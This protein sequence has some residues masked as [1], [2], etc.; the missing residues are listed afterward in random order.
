MP[1]SPPNP[2]INC[3]QTG[4]LRL[5]GE[6][7]W[8][9]NATF[10]VDLDCAGEKVEAVYKPIKG[11]Q[12]LWDFPAESL[13]CREVAAYLLSEALGWGLVPPTVYRQQGPLG[14]GSLQWRVPHDPALHYFEFNQE[15]R[16]ALRP[17]ALFDLIANNADRKGGHILVAE[18]GGF[19]LIDQGLCF[20]AEAK[21]RTVIWDFRGEA[22]PADLL[23]DLRR[24]AAN[25]DGLR[26][27][28]A[29]LLSPDE[30][31]ALK[32]RLDDW[33]AIGHFPMPPENMRAVPYPL[34]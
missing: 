12:P 29:E 4:E 14:P 25:F 23:D 32:A 19:Q 33:I 22:I 8:G 18:G 24:L 5:V 13:A 9:S 17:T 28:L 3:L 16:Q 20:H 1:S 7:V 30:I 11:E 6:F 15:L 26:A 31:D 21:L 27:E 34:V 10:L 2:L